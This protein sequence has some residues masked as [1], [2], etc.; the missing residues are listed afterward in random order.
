[1]IIGTG[2][3]IV[4]LK[5]IQ[6]ILERQE[7]TF[8]ARIFTEQERVRVPKTMAR[9]VEFVAGRYAAKEALSKAVGTGIGRHFSFQDAE[10]L[11]EESGKPVI[12]MDASLLEKMTGWRGCM[13]HVSISHSEQYA[14][15]QVILERREDL[16]A[17]H[18]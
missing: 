6:K 4:E 5:R 9:R 12:N 1:M 16:S 3:D 2:I 18:E 8:L 15:A 10:I 13:L 11:A 7:E 14:I 17:Y